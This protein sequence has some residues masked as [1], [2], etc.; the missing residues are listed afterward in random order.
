M[1]ACLERE[2]RSLLFSSAVESMP[3]SC[4]LLAASVRISFS[5]AC[6]T[7]VK[8]V[9]FRFETAVAFAEPAAAYSR[10]HPSSG[11]DRYGSLPINETNFL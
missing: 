7:L 2:L 8:V 10:T 5:F 1:A 6:I 11:C 3:V 4:C 9:P